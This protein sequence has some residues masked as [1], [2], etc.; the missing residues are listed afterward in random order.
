MSNQG[1][2]PASSQRRI[3]D[4]AYTL[5][6]E[7]GMA[8]VTM[9]AVAERAGVSRQTLYN[10]HPNVESVI[11]AYLLTEISEVS[12]QLRISLS[13]MG[14][15]VA[16]LRSFIHGAVERFAK[17]DIQ[18]SMTYVMSPASAKLIDQ[19]VNSIREVLET[20]I[21]EG[22]ES[23]DFTTRLSAERTS[24]LIFQMLGGIAHMMTSTSDRRALADD[25]FEVLFKGLNG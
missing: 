4:A 16:Q 6:E 11:L 8:D 10:N 2:K 19:G 25:V 7:R 15:P 18:M 1:A 5:V 17:R 14:D 12:A 24:V 20:V 23:G 13:M 22:I 3:L 9:T 21:N